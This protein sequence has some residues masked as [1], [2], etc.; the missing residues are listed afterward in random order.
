[1]CGIC[2]FIDKSNWGMKILN[3]MNN[4]MI[5]RGPDDSGVW[6]NQLGSNYIGMAHRRL[7][8]IDVS[9]LGHQPMISQDGN[10]IIVFNGEIYNFK[11][12]RNI[13]EE[14]GYKFKSNCDTEV[15]LYAYC[16]WG[17]EA[18]SKLNGMF[19]ICICDILNNQVILARDR[20][21]KKPLY[22]YKNNDCFIFA[23]ELKAIMKY[24][25]FK[26]DI[27]NRAILN[28]LCY[29][30]INAPETIFENTFKLNAGELL[31]WNAGNIRTKKYWDIYN[32]YTTN[33]AHLENDYKIAK[34]NVKRKIIDAVSCRM[35][36]DVPLGLFLSGG[37]D[38]TLIAAIASDIFTER[39]K[40]FS[41]G[42]EDKS[43][44]EANLAKETA[45]LLDC[46]HTELYVDET[47]LLNMLDEIPHYF[48]EPFADPSE[49]PTMLVS[50]LAKNSVTVALSGDG[51]DELFCGYSMYDYL[52]WFQK[53]DLL[54]N[55]LYK[56][57]NSTLLSKIKFDSVLPNELKAVINNRDIN[58]KTQLF[59]DLP[60]R[61]ASNMLKYASPNS[62]K[63]Q[64]EEK[65]LLENWQ[66]RRMLLDMCTYLP[67]DILTKTDRASMHYSL[68]VRCPLLD[69]NIVEYSFKIP[70]KFKYNR[71]EKKYILKDILSDYMPM[72]MVK[73]PKKGFGVPLGNWL[74]TSLKERILYYADENKLKK[75]G[76]FRYETV[77][78]L[79]SLVDKSD[80][81]PYPKLLWSFLVFQMWYEYYIE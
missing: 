6:L 53:T 64:L 42:F 21:G 39:I 54:A 48:D 43:R 70:H 11:E 16:K 20:I 60:E 66:Y 28:Y 75:Q 61:F 41:I 8:I 23:S 63:Y 62:V 37:I 9:P 81:K 45:T 69:Y 55:Y 5:H 51:G 27:N 79:I 52:F 57:N 74:R 49:I 47:L 2:G 40:T 67:E 72:N 34:A 77:L 35:E 33:K 78:Q 56:L 44:N 31:I 15:A 10:C 1:M 36:A 17:I 50:K 14:Y 29:Q 38:S 22:Y 7:S 30:Y 24:P 80:R 73:R 71:R 18:F 3:E 58:T 76:I 68:E 4:T 25:T 12:L 46:D 65:F 59:I 26:K 19:A 13:L 32:V